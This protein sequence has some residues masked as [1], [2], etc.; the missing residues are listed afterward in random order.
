[1]KDIRQIKVQ[2]C[3]TIEGP[4]FPKALQD[5]VDFILFINSLSL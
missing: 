4:T 1:M 5:I 3:G 2:E